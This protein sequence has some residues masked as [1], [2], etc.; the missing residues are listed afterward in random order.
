MH[1][2]NN[3]RVKFSLQSIQKDIGAHLVF[4]QW[5]S[6]WSNL[7]NQCNQCTERQCML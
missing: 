3:F 2:I 1:K 6:D 5:P 4:L 7:K